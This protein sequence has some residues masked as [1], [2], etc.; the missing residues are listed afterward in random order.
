MKSKDTPKS[1]LK[2][3]SLDVNYNHVLTISE[4]DYLHK[5][6]EETIVPLIEAVKTGDL[7]IIKII[8][9]HSIQSDAK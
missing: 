6:V 8:I 4:G 7:E 5:E 2:I 9:N 3:D 1:L